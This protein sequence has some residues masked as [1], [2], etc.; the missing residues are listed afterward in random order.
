MSAYTLYEYAVRALC[1]ESMRTYSR[2]KRAG[3][4]QIAGIGAAAANFYTASRENATKRGEI[5][6]DNMHASRKFAADYPYS[7]PPES[8]FVALN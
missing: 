7:A 5:A 4:R 6:R 3:A 1:M 2:N 8:E